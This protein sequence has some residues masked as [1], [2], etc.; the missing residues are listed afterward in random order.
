MP[1]GPFRGLC[2]LCVLLCVPGMAAL[3]KQ[4]PWLTSCLGD[5]KGSLA[6]C[7]PS[8][9]HSVPL[10]FHPT[11]GCSGKE[12]GLSPHGKAEGRGQSQAGCAVPRAEPAAQCCVS[13]ERCRAGNVVAQ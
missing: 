12:V 13:V 10:P 7:H 2:W 5:M 11:A 6:C 1:C 4:N 8:H 9:C 3:T